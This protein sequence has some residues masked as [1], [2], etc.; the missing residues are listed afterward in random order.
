MDSQVTLDFS[1]N[2]LTLL[3]SAVYYK[4]SRYFDIIRTF[5]D[6]DVSEYRSMV[7][8][9]YDDLCSLY[10]RLYNLC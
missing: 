6:D 10:N 8:S 3:V 5:D 2:E 1:V 4:M 7:L 9:E